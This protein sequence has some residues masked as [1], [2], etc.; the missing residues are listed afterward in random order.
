[1]AGARLAALAGHQDPLGD[2]P[3]GAIPAQV[4][5]HHV[6]LL[7]VLRLVAAALVL[8]GRP[9]VEPHHDHAGRGVAVGIRVVVARQLDLQGLVV[10]VD[11]VDDA[12]QIRRFRL[13]LEPQALAV[14][15]AIHGVGTVRAAR[16][17][18]PLAADVI[19]YMDLLGDLAV[20]LLFDGGL[21]AVSALQI[22]RPVLAALVLHGRVVVVEQGDLIAAIAVAPAGIEDDDMVAAADSQHRPLHVAA[23]VL[24]AA[25]GPV[26]TARIPRR[27]IHFNPAAG[28][29]DRR[30]EGDRQA[31]P[32]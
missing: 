22:L 3:A 12:P 15:P 11:V 2:H 13:T 27:V 32:T 6:P 7:Q 29:H 17:H 1:P 24:V 16:R 18:A 31:G 10:R 28:R 9:V 8:D 26:V 25:P 21:D 4:D 19:G 5:L 14:R 23:T 30:G 20:S